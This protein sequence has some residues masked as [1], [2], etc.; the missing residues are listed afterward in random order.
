MSI[1]IMTLVFKDETLDS[2]KKLVM[3]SLADNANDQG[4]CYPSI[5]NI[6]KKT[7]LS[8][9]TIIKHL[10]ELEQNN[11]I[12]SK[13]RNTKQNKKGGG[14]LSTIYVVYPKIHISVLDEDI[15][16]RFDIKKGQSK[17]A[18]LGSQSKE[19]LPKN[20]SQ[21][22]EATPKPSLTLFNHHLFNKLNKE[23]K[24]LF[25]EYLKLRKKMKLQTTMQIQI[26]LLEKYFKFGKK[27]EII[28]NAINANWKD[29]YP[30]KNF[31]TVQEKNNEIL[32][33]YFPSNKQEF[34]DVSVEVAR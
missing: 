33:R 16:S 3:L 4:F 22:K 5:N 15:L 13:K 25:L 12:L 9:P 20:D 29:F 30:V 1:K 21:S 7:S 18:L 24:D 14:R 31:K 28:E 11:F 6:V 23:E 27:I 34:I 10:K 26:R 19:A 8:K 17:E 2:N 32:D